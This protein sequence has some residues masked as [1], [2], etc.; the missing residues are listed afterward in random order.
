MAT[1]YYEVL[2]VRADCTQAEVK[3][4]FKLKAIKVHSDKNKSPNADEAFKKLNNAQLVLAD[5][6]ARA[7]YDKYMDIEAY[8]RRD[9]VPQ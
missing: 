7:V 1:C 8:Q 4:A 9:E 3:K 5:S 6:D 2:G